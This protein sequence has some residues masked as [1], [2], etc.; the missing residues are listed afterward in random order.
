MF[1]N[2]LC[3]LCVLIIIS[4][5]EGYSGP[6]LQTDDPDTP[7][8]GNWEINIAII[9]ERTMAEKS[10]DTPLLDINYGLGDRIQLKLEIPWVVLDPAGNKTITS[11]G[12]PLIGL[13]WRFLEDQQHDF[14]L[15]AYPQFEFDNPI[16]SS[17]G[18]I[19][20][21]GTVFL[22]PIQM[23]KAFGRFEVLL[24]FGGLFKQFDADEWVYGL[25]LVYEV[26]KDFDIL[27]ELRGTAYQDFLEDKLLF[28]LGFTW[29]LHSHYTLLFAAGR[30]IRN[31][32]AD[33]T[34]LFILYLALQLNI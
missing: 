34:E 10:Y 27:G 16:T 22:L 18:R 7:G 21:T 28:N 24:E 9:L 15:S 2:I 11:L 30:N 4:P 12:K 23:S 3:I 20:D 6:P 32:S 31:E 13:K 25:A 8:N 1:I 26:F 5:E 29:K 14:A 17:D 19:V 33:E